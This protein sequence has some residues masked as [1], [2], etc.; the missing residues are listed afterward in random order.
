MAKKAGRAFIAMKCWLQLGKA[1]DIFSLL[2]I[3]HEE[4]RLSG[5][6]QNLIVSREYA[7]VVEG[8]DYIT[9]VIFDGSYMDFN[10]AFKFAKRHFDRV[11]TP[12]TH[13]NTLTI[14][15]KTPSVFFEQWERVGYL[16]KWDS[17]PLV[18]P[19][20]SKTTLSGPTILYC[21]HS[22]SSPFFFKDDLY[23][24]LQETFPT[25]QI[26]RA[27]GM[28]LKNLRDFLPIM[29]N[30]DLIVSVETS[31]LHLSK[32]T[33][34]PTVAMCADAP[35]TWRGSPYSKHFAFHCRYG[36]F[37]SRKQELVAAMVR[38]VNKVVIPTPSR[39]IAGR[40]NGY[41]MCMATVNNTR[42]YI[43]RHHPDNN[44]KTKLAIDENTRDGNYRTQDIAFPKECD[45]YSLEDAR[46]FEL[47][48][49]PHLAYTCSDATSGR[50]FSIQ[51]FG[52]LELVGDQWRVTKH[53]VPKY[54]GNNFTMIQ[55]NWVP[56]VRG[57]VLHFI[58]GNLRTTMEQV[59]LQMDGDKVVKEHRSPAPVWNW[60]G[61]R[62][63]C[64]IPFKGHLLRFFHSRTGDT[65]KPLGFRYFCGASLLEAEP[66]FKTVATSTFPIIAGDES[67]IPNCAHWKPNVVFPLGVITDGDKFIV[68]L[69]INDS[70]CAT[71]TFSV[72]DL[73][74]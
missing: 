16:E 11:E 4:F 34:T 18:L 43:Y 54:E 41:N 37:E 13:G 72:S 67:Y 40:D 31:F 48:G 42:H 28:R 38:A 3:L 39:F 6:S 33:T 50:F 69:G 15:R 60:G 57:G 21:D 20:T 7:S 17:I 2:P 51:A 47:N 66:P 27:S 68:S 12:Q 32:A 74:L 62:G 24:L 8:L 35:D 49:K 59:I 71:L 9:P 19:R 65:N 55:K 45:N 73:N 46:F 64:V 56:F 44:W 70:A 58:F 23:K 63:G 36:D 14:K 10:G 53:I 30:A 25:H 52:P 61:I 22:Q 29:D 26:M 1:G 5:Q